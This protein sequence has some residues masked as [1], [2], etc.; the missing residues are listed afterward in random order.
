MTDILQDSIRLCCC[1]WV[2]RE[3][4]QA[5]SRVGLDEASRDE[6]LDAWG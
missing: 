6:A 5:A 2:E 4:K 1:T 3:A